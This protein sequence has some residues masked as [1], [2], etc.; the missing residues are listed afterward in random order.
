[1][2]SAVYPGSFNPW[3][4]GHDDVLAKALGAFEH[5]TVVQMD[6]PLK[7]EAKTPLP[8]D[9]IYKVYGN[10]VS[11][12]SFHG[13]LTDYVKQFEPCAVIR[14]LRNG[15][16]FEFEKT[17]QYWNEDLGIRCPFVYFISDRSLV[18]VSSSAIRMVDQLKRAYE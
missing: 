16:D 8:L 18:H 2:K 6:N 3:H 17:Q 12:L 14:G 13:M 9:V 1:M 5:V 15:Q 4:Q 7:N 11:C 10:R